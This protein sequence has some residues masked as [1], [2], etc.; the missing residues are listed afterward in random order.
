MREIIEIEVGG[1]GTQIGN[2]FWEIIGEE[3]RIDKNGHYE[4]H[5]EL[6]LE[7]INVYYKEEEG[8]YTPRAILVDLNPTGLDEIKVGNLGKLFK[9]E[10]LF[11]PETNKWN[12]GGT[13]N[14]WA[15][16]HYT[17]GAEEVDKVMDMIRWEAEECENIQ[18]F[19][20]E[21]SLGGGTGSGMGTLICS[22]LREEY[23]SKIISTYSVF[24]SEKVSNIFVEPYN[25]ILSMM[26]L[27]QEV[28]QVITLDNEELYHINL[29]VP[30]YR[31]MNYLVARGMSG[32]TSSFRFPTGLNEDMGRLS[33]H[34]VPFPRLHFFI[35]GIAPIATFPYITHNP[36]SLVEHMLDSKNIL[37]GVNPNDGKYLAAGG[38]F[39]G[40]M[41]PET[42][43]NGMEKID[44]NL[45]N[46][47]EYKE[48]EK[49][50]I[51]VIQLSGGVPERT[52]A[53]VKET[54]A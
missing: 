16:G 18:G 17:E 39:R 33:N 36:N 44:H 2:N 32:T 25:C 4:G 10:N 6:E 5:S 27:I 41:T 1:C 3:H 9:R 23:P 47:T 34:L 38:M 49:T 13:G 42:I 48:E 30:N 51:V 35:Q 46:F 22:K 21:H 45:M 20:L 52:G 53:P 29:N 12:S 15:K 19:Q 26:D 28:D 31:D 7:Q 50:L 54:T 40:E 8:R 37:C 24:P 43:E 14:N 11:V